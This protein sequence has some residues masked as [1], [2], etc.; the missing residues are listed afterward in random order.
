[1]YTLVSAVTWVVVCSCATKPGQPPGVAAT[2]ATDREIKIG[3][4]FALHSKILNEERRYWVHL[5]ESYS[6][7]MFA[8]QKYPV[9][10]LL[11]GDA[12][13]HMA[14]GVVHFMGT[15]LNGNIQI[16][17]LIIVAIPNTE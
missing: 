15:G 17:E 13:F 1:L 16:P 12:N 11:D 10:Y 5:P 9:L 4:K 2:D 6:N 7:R 3:E 8:P 14:S